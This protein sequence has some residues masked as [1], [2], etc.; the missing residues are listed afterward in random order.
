MK[1]SAQEEYGIRCLLQIA[2]LEPV[3]S[4]TIPEISRIEGMSAT[5]VAKLLMILRKSGFIASTRGHLG[6]YTLARPADQISVGDVLAALGGR[7][8]DDAFCD[9][10]SG[11][12]VTCTHA[13]ACNVRSVWQIVQGAVDSV[14]DRVTLADLMDGQFSASNVR[15]MTSRPKAETVS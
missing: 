3:A 15:F 12:N 11:L 7:L 5:H 14:L 1:F 8:Y 6:G 2:K 13:E 4:I 10:H 9:R